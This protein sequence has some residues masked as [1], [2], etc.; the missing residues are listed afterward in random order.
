MNSNTLELEELAQQWPKHG[1]TRGSGMPARARAANRCAVWLSGIGADRLRAS[2]SVHQLDKLQLTVR[3]RVR[4]SGA[5][6]V[7]EVGMRMLDSGRPDSGRT[8]S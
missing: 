7:H 3:E 5:K 4:E 8:L 6:R 1:G 2:A